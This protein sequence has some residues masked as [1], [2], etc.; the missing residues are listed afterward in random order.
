MA[1]ADLLFDSYH[2]ELAQPNPLNY[3][4][5]AGFDSV[6]HSGYARGLELELELTQTH[7]TQKPMP[8]VEVGACRF[9]QQT[10]AAKR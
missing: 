1:E 4:S 8:R 9:A 2:D 7:M 10:S 3:G 5:M 6:G